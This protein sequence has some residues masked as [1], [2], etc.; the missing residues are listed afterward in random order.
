MYK[1]CSCEIHMADVLVEYCQSEIKNSER[2][3]DS[4][5]D[6]RSKEIEDAGINTLKRTINKISFITGKDYQHEEATNER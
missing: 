3:R 2:I 1:V 5:R 6:R 4:V